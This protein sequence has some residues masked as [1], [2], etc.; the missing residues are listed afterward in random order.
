[1]SEYRPL[2]YGDRITDIYDEYVSGLPDVGPM[3]ACPQWSDY[4]VPDASE[5]MVARPREK[6]GV[7]AIAI[8][9]GDWQHLAL[10]SSKH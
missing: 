8:T 10:R 2:T 4:T 3:V 7:P 1:M 6:N 9:K 5:T